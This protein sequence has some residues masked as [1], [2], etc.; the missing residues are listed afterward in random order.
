MSKDILIVDDSAT[1]RAMIN[2][3][4]RIISLEGGDVHVLVAEDAP[5]E[6]THIPEKTT[7]YVD[8]TQS[9]ACVWERA[10]PCFD[11]PA[12]SSDNPS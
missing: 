3:A 10:R 9:T 6:L 2:R 4:V 1:I 12:V 5:I 8:R 7:T 11:K